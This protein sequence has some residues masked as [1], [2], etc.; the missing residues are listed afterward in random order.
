MNEITSMKELSVLVRSGFTEWGALGDVMVKRKD[1]LILFNYSPKAQY[2]DRWNWFERNSRGLILDE[3]TGAVVARPFE[4]FFNWM[5]RA[6][7]T[8]APV[9]TVWE[10]L[11]GSLG[12]CYRWNGEW[13][14]ATRGS[15]DSPQAQWATEWVRRNQSLLQPP[16]ESP[17]VLFEIIYPEN[18]VVVDYG[19]RAECVLLAVRDNVSGTY[20]YPS[21]SSP[22]PTPKHYDI[23]DPTELTKLCQKLDANSE[24]FVAEFADGQRFKFK[25]EEYKKLHR[26]IS[27]LSFKYAV[28]VVQAGTVEQA[29]GAVPDEFLSEFN[30]WVEDIQ[31]LVEVKTHNV[32]VMFER[33]PKEDRK[34]FAL[35]AKQYCP[36]LMHYLFAKLDGRD[37]LPLIYRQEFG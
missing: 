15:F 9:K 21:A 20:S 13:R 16:Y 2:E 19:E 27:G 30:G 23:S 33:A 29:R 8:L 26:L 25:G 10:K 28:E 11:D 7:F 35:W 22:Y 17:T 5:E 12:I 6:R 1:G 36:E 14:V 18:R 4:K 31:D 3:K 24:G 32:E 34:T 37:Y